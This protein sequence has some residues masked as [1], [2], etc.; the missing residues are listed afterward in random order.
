MGIKKVKPTSPGRR[1]YSVSTFEEIT[2]TEPYFPLLEIKKKSGGRNN[3][4]RITARHRGGGEKRYYRVIDFKRDK[5]GIPAVV[6]SI[7]YDPNRSARIALVCYAD[8]EYRYIIAPEGLKVGVRIISGSGSP[9]QIGNAL[10]LREIPV[11]VEIHNIQLQPHERARLVRSAGASAQILAKEGDYAYVK[12][13]S[14]EV[15]MIHLDC[16]ATIGRVSN[17]EHENIVIGKAGRKRHMGR[18]PRVRAI[19]MNPVDHPMGG[20]EGRSKSGKHPKSP[21]GLLAKG[22]KTRKRNKP[23][24][25]F[26]VQRRK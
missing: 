19:A 20:G 21:T 17:P 5:H 2:T 14:N 6:K 3:L 13:P 11:G 16:Y 7:E 23:S 25:K 9:I 22:K 1:F 18:R 24:D 8:G 10:P 4:G 12:L 15:R 26:I